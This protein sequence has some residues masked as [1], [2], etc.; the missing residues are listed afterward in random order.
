MVGAE[1]GIRH[2]ANYT[3]KFLINRLGALIE[4]N[5]KVRIPG[6]ITK[7]VVVGGVLDIQIYKFIF[8]QKVTKK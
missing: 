2:L 1:E 4:D 3:Q 5:I 8:L 7:E 6:A